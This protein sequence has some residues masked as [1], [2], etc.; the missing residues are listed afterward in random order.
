MKKLLTF[1]IILLLSISSYGKLSDEKKSELR[2][3]A[4]QRIIDLINQHRIKGKDFPDGA[5]FLNSNDKFDIDDL[6]GSL[7]LLYFFAPHSIHSFDISSRVNE[8]V[9]KYKDKNLLVVGVS[10][11]HYPN[12]NS[13]SNVNSF[14][15]RTNIQFPVV[16]DTK[17]EMKS[18]Y[19]VETYPSFIL[20]DPRGTII[21]KSHGENDFDVME[22]FIEKAYELFERRFRDVK[23]NFYKTPSAI[24]SELKFP[25]DIDVNDD[26]SE[27]Y[28][29]DTGNNRVLVCDA[30]GKIT[31]IYGSEKGLADGESPK[32][33][34]PAGIAYFE[35]TLIVADS[36]ND[37][38]R[39][40]DLKKETVSTI[41][42]TDI[43]DG[44]RNTS[45]E[46][47]KITIDCPWGVTRYFGDIYITEPKKNRV[48]HLD[49]KDNF[50]MVYTGTGRIG[51]G[52]GYRDI[53]YFAQ[54]MGIV[55]TK[56]EIYVADAFSNA[57]RLIDLAADGKVSTVSGG[58]IVYFGDK[59][60]NKFNSLF[61]SPLG[62]DTDGDKIYITDTYNNKVKIID[63]KSG[64]VKTINVSE[65]MDK[66]EGVKY[67]NGYLYVVDRGN[68]RILKIEVKS[69]NTMVLEIK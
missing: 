9:D 59:D 64:D 11:G 10:E 8:V 37:R 61:T 2:S 34:H 42:G 19:E 52:D 53:A 57:I 1:L 4:K 44:Q 16:I 17:G 69:G 66:P 5:I 30:T 54:P 6:S 29:S 20:M 62:I 13:E 31:K 50:M 15:Q 32:F 45:S 26:G 43:V 63:A 60:G 40:V 68:H 36:G 67:R 23:E 58:D 27:I 47:D 24:T 56:Y 38:I 25:V 3:E 21:A 22:I 28:I 46:S 39:K 12:E 51:K 35:N 41:A 48:W 14:M 18:D 65:K 55:S 7:L 49:L 33:F